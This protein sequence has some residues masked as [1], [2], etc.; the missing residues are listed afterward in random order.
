MNPESDTYIDL[1]RH[2]EPVGGRRYRGQ[3]DDPLSDKGWQQMR[4]AVTG[5]DEWE[6]IWSSPLKRCA[7]F[8]QELATR[9]Q[10]PLTLDAR[11]KEIGFGDWEGQT[12]DELRRTDP[13]RLERFWRDPVNHRPAGAETL[14]AFQSRVQAVWNDII[15]TH[16]GR[17]VLV[18]GHA[19][20]TRMVVSLALG[21][22]IEHMF[23]IQVGNAELTR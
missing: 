15:A 14:A 22:P 13:E 21:S 4:T 1:L 8:A 19:G 20:I 12:A 5:R 17:R 23:R 6:V 3:I 2:G 11:L 10:L 7:E 9:R 18:V 16:P